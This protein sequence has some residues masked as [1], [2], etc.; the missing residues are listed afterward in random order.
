MRK[1]FLI[2]VIATLSAL[3]SAQSFTPNIGLALPPFGATNWNIQANGNFSII[4]SAIGSMQNLYQGVWQPTTVYAKGQLV[5]Y[6]LQVFASLVPNNLNQNPSS[7]MGFWILIPLASSSLDPTKVPLAG[8]TMTGAL[9]LNADPTASLGASTKNYV[10]TSQ[11]VNVKSC[12]AVGDN[13]TDDTTAIQN[14]LTSVGS[15]AA[16]LYFPCGRY[17]TSNQLTLVLPIAGHGAAIVGENPECA[18]IKYTGS[19]PISAVLQVTTTSGNTT[20]IYFTNLLVRD[21]SLEGNANVTHDLQLVRP[22]HSWIE[23]VRMW[24]A[25]STNGDCLNVMAGV[26]LDYKGPICDSFVDQS[27]AAKPFNG[28]VFTGNNA[29]DLSTT[30]TITTPIVESG[31][32][33]SGGA[34][35]LLDWAGGLVFT[36]CQISSWTQSLLIENSGGNYLLGCLF[37]DGSMSSSIS[38]SYNVIDGGTFSGTNNAGGT[39][40]VNGTGNVI[41]NGEYGY[42]LTVQS[43]ALLTTISNEDYGATFPVDNGAGTSISGLDENPAFNF[44][45]D[46]ANTISNPLW[47]AAANNGPETI[48]GAWQI[49]T[50]AVT[51]SPT[52]ITTGKSWRAILRGTFSN[53][54]NTEVTT[55]MPDWIEIS[56]TNNVVTLPSASTMTFS[57]GNTG[58]TA[59]G[60]ACC[61]I[62]SGWIDF[63]PNVSA[64]TSGSNSMSLQGSL[65]VNG[66]TN[67]LYRCSVAGI[68]RIGQ[69]TTVSGDCG[70][71]VD[72]GLRVP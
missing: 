51:I 42:G 47:T 15:S 38:S 16:T 13:S 11:R 36:G 67:I 37:E 28:L 49:G 4:D 23:N 17:I 50:P 7:P 46:I 3:A 18:K 6:N 22:A 12:G 61:E 14:C 66:G 45:T 40:L 39:I 34:A 52:T 41:K 19:A 33:A 29:S 69:T 35:I 26:A 2:A 31:G 25:S 68:L 9:L 71:A 10:D 44:P 72:T 53:T 54:A 62:F 56:E 48:H 1:I 64:T 60:S 21:I 20:G 59:I 43:G 70:T 30:S 63:Y 58:L 24:G 32:G 65:A 5:T 57:V 55:S 8:G 27:N